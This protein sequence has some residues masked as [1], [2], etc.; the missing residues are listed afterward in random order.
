M[1]NFG[2]KTREWENRRPNALFNAYFVAIEWVSPG[3]S[4]LHVWLGDQHPK[5]DLLVDAVSHFSPAS[6]SYSYG[7]P[8]LPMLDSGHAAA[9]N[10][11]NE[12]VSAIFQQTQN[13]AELLQKHLRLL[14]FFSKDMLSEK[15]LVHVRNLY[16]A[17]ITGQYL[18][19]KINR[20]NLVQ[21][22]VDPM[23][24]VFWR[25]NYVD[26]IDS[27][28]EGETQGYFYDGHSRLKE[29]ELICL[30]LERNKIKV[31]LSTY[32][33]GR[34]QFLNDSPH[35]KFLLTHPRSNRGVLKVHPFRNQQELSG[36]LKEY[37]EPGLDLLKERSPHFLKTAYCNDQAWEAARKANPYS[38]DD[39]SQIAA[40]CACDHDTARR[41]IFAASNQILVGDSALTLDQWIVEGYLRNQY[42]FEFVRCS[43]DAQEIIQRRQNCQF[44]EF[45]CIALS[46]AAHDLILKKKVKQMTELLD[47]FLQNSH[48]RPGYTQGL[49]MGNDSGHDYTTDPR[50]GPTGW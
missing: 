24:Y 8:V 30:F 47:G 13:G 22:Q 7:D 50:L 9:L 21:L 33:N 17:V 1:N 27:L 23:G 35:T 4:H 49:S 16:S 43:E 12:C 38:Q 31:E 11:K 5:S 28:S 36:V 14:E 19:Q 46:T 10:S 39:C 44:Q 42:H 20:G 37:A 6:Y 32:K 40:I 3:M 29:I 48:Q 18:D 25:G 34:D 15:D 45:R 41:I 2:E 26:H